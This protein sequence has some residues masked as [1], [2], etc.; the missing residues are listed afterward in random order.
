MKDSLK[1]YE[2]LD[3]TKLYSIKEISYYNHNYYIGFKRN[4]KVTND[5]LFAES[6]DDN[7]TEIYL[8]EG[9]NS[10]HIGYCYT[11]D[12]NKIILD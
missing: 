2:G 4:N 10:I 1:I 8:I 7:T 12:E 11:S 5:L 6:D 3:L 9:S